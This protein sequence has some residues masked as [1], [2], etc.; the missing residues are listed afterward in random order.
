MNIKRQQ[1]IGTIG[2]YYGELTV[3]ED[4]QGSKYWSIE[5]WDG[6]HWQRIPE[7]LYEAL[8]RFERGTQ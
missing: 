3:G 6:H 4:D 8:L 2:N 5:N 1:A 7:D